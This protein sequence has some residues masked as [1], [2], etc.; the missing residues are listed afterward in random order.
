VFGPATLDGDRL[1]IRPMA[2]ERVPELVNTIVS[3]GGRIHEVRSGRSS[4]EQRFVELVSRDRS[5]A[6]SAGAEERPR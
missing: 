4:L 1:A 6:G 2:G 3:M 5:I